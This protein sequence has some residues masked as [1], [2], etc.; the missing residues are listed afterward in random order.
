MIE[1]WLLVKEDYH[2]SKGKDKF[3]DQSILSFLKAIALIRQNSALSSLTR[4]NP[5]LRVISTLLGLVLIS[6]TRSFPFLLIIDGLLLIEWIQLNR[7]ER[8]RA[9]ILSLVFPL[10]AF[11]ALIPAMLQGNFSN[12]LLLC[13]KMATSIL[14]VQSLSLRTPWNEL[15]KALKS[16]FVPDLV[17]WIMDITLKY[18]VLLG[19][20]ST[21]L[22]FAL[23]LRSV[24]QTGDK[25]GAVSGIIGGLFLK[26]CR[27]GEEMAEAM[28]CRGFVGEY[29]VP[30]RRSFTRIDYLYILL[31]LLLASFFL[32]Q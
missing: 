23:K 16:I 5:S 2:P 19:D 13:Q 30:T 4:I 28:E 7:V 21:N 1:D 14:L 22:L 12:S 26:S 8:K 10:I 20:Y 3:I 17:I 24:G 11:I 27:M 18:I 6:L 15:T 29:R 9:I 31:N 25:F 32:F